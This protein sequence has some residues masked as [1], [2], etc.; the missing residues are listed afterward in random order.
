MTGDRRE[1]AERLGFETIYAEFTPDQKASRIEQMQRSGRRV[2][3][4]GDGVNDAAAMA[5][6]DVGI[7]VAEG[8]EI[9]VDVA[10][11]T[12]HGSE[13][14]RL[15]EAIEQADRSV[16]II[17]QNLWYALG[18]NVVGIAAAAAGLLHPVLAA[19]LMV[20]SSSLVTWRTTLS[21]EAHSSPSSSTSVS[22]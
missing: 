3:Y 18:Y 16:G 12:W 22:T 14:R 8:S 1:R 9:T 11:M 10:D 7:A 4:V 13:P 17:R 15:V 6:A 20:G 21:L 19:L 5:R 2:L